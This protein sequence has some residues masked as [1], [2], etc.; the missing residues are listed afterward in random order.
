MS[1]ADA[2][3]TVNEEECFTTSTHMDKTGLE[4]ALVKN[5]RSLRLIVSLTQT[6]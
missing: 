4:M 6:E 3:A 1:T 2:V 5:V